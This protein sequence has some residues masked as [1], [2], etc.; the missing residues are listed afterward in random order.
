MALT[1]I[2]GAGWSF[3]EK[4]TSAQTNALDISHAN[5]IDKRVG[6]LEIGAASITRVVPYLWTPRT[7]AHWATDATTGLWWTFV[8][9]VTATACNFRLPDGATL[10]S[11][12]VWIDPANGHA[13]LPVTMPRIDVESIDPDHA[14]PI[15]VL[16]NATDTSANAAA[17]D[18]L[19]AITA[20]GIAHTASPSTVG[21]RVTLWTESGGNAM[22]ACIV[23]GAIINFT[24]ARL[25]EW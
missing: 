6:A 12:A 5:A 7:I 17:F 21:Y 18:A 8:D 23:R 16:A 2:K 25:D 22:S 9:A 3:G 1:R 20:S 14:S 10:N 24:C 15:T 11:V 13:G 19:H 4:L